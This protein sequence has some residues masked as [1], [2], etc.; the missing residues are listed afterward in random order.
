[1]TADPWPSVIWTGALFAAIGFLAVWGQHI[2][3]QC[4]QRRE[5]ARI[6][7]GIAAERDPGRRAAWRTIRDHNQGDDQ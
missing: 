3:D 6:N 5:A 2:S 1:M 4:R 7:S